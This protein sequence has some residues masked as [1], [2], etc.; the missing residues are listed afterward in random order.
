MRVRT[1]GIANAARPLH[2][3]LPCPRTWRNLRNPGLRVLWFF[4]TRRVPLPPSAEEAAL[5]L[6]YFATTRDNT[7]AVST[8]LNAMTALCEL[9][10]WRSDIYNARLALAPVDAMR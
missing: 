5:L 1:Y 7:G 4:A 9:N 6:T 2:R 10:G 8:A 3:Q